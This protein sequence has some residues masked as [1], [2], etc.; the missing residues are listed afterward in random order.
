MTHGPVDDHRPA[1]EHSNLERQTLSAA[2][3]FER[4]VLAR[5]RRNV[6]HG[7]QLVSFCPIHDDITQNPD[8]PIPWSGNRKPLMRPPTGHGHL[9]GLERLGDRA[10]TSTAWPADRMTRFPVV[11]RKAGAAMSLATPSQAK[12]QMQN[13]LKGAITNR[14]RET[15]DDVLAVGT[16]STRRERL[17]HHH[18]RE[19]IPRARV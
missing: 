6:S 13:G 19:K 7:K 14:S 3:Q 2:N 4:H 11:Y 18:D 9:Y 1:L 15:F 12:S 10:F 8:S 5:Y 17:S 16:K